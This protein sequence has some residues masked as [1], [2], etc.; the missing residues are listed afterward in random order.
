MKDPRDVSLRMV[1]VLADDF[2]DGCVSWRSSCVSVPL[3][4]DSN[5]LSDRVQLTL[6]TLSL[7]DGQSWTIKLV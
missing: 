3:T 4:V 5:L 7:C 1:S 6:T 2:V